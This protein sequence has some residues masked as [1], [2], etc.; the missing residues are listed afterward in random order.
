MIRKNSLQRPGF[1]YTSGAVYFVTICTHDSEP[2]LGDVVHGVSRPA[3][4]GTITSE[5]WF[6]LPY[7]YANLQ[8]GRFVIMPN[9]VHATLSLSDPIRAGLRPAPTTLQSRTEGVG[10]SEIV[11]AFKAFSA[12]KINASRRV[13]AVPVWQ[14]GFY[15]RIVRNPEELRRIH[16]YME[17]NAAQWQF[18][19]ENPERRADSRLGMSSD[20]PEIQLG[21]GLRSALAR[22]R[23]RQ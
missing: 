2:I 7:H 12:R 21:T 19:Q 20:L 18:D 16:K 1:D 6:E 13:H 10:L 4:A 15:D 9:H 3:A 22:A 11:R 8:L 5:C 23:R 14:R 17:E